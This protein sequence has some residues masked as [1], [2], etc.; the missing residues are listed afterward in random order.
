MKQSPQISSER[1][2]RVLVADDDT[3]LAERMV[4]FLSNNGFYTRYARNGLEV[5]NMLLTWK[6]DFILIDLFLAETNALQFLK[7][8]GPGQMGEDK[9]KVIVLSGHSHETN[10]REC[11]RAGAIDYMVKPFKY[12]DLLSRLVLHTQKK[13]T[14]LDVDDSAHKANP[15]ADYFLHLTDLT[16]QESLKNLRLEETLHNLT[17]MVS[18]ALNAVR[19]S[20]VQCDV[21]ARSGQ[22]LGSSDLRH[23]RQLELDLNKYPE[24]LYVLQSKQLL[25]LDN[26]ATDPQMAFVARQNKSIHFNSMIVAPLSINQHE[27]W[28]VLSARMNEA[29]AS[30]SD[31]E[32]RFVQLV[33]HVVSLA[34]LKDR[35]QAQA[36]HPHKKTA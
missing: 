33:S 34:L 29:K 24:I 13:R 18:L 17:R 22:V 3:L 19:V 25:A 20:I 30:L 16:L 1:E 27:P 8:L 10:V 11:L 28:G 5:K 4:D 15:N 35:S 14:L 23:I 21:E 2:V 9:I 31:A 6:P 26:L 12:V 32:I 36:G 7:F